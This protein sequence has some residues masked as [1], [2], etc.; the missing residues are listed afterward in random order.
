MKNQHYQD[1]L[2]FKNLQFTILPRFVIFYRA[3]Q[4]DHCQGCKNIPAYS[5]NSAG[6]EH[7][8]WDFCGNWAHIVLPKSSAVCYIRSWRSWKILISTRF[9]VALSPIEVHK[10]VKHQ[11]QH[12]C[13][14]KNVTSSGWNHK[15]S[16]VMLS[17]F[18]PG[19][20]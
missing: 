17:W 18:W 4:Q 9:H 2:L 19:Q 3:W 1:L 14:Q 8:P 7:L 6:F 5:H 15:H 16:W 12:S 10:N 11:V 20:G 13:T